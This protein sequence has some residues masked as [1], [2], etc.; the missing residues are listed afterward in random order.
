MIDTKYAIRNATNMLWYTEDHTLPMCDRWSP[1]IYDAA[2][3]VTKD[4][5]ETE[6]DVDNHGLDFFNIFEIK[7]KS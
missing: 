6:I 3:Y 7:I 5:A 1:N 4:A 2:L